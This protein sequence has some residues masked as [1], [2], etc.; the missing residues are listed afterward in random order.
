MWDKTSTQL[1][2]TGWLPFLENPN[3]NITAYSLFRAIDMSARTITTQLVMAE[4]Y[5][6]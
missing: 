6:T 2:I 5:H 4:T 3:E 1:D